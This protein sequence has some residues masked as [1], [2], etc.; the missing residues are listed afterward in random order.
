MA[1]PA[2]APLF[3]IVQ[4]EVS[5]ELDLLHGRWT[6]RGHANRPLAVVVV[7]TTERPRRR[8]RRGR[9][10]DAAGTPI[11]AAR[12]T[13]VD[14]DPLEVPDPER[15]LADVD[16]PAALAAA[17]EILDQL[18]HLHA[19]ASEEPTPR[20]L[21]ARDLTR[22]TV[23]YGTGPEGADGRWTSERRLAVLADKPARIRRTGHGIGAEERLAELLSGRDAPL[24]AETLGLRAHHDLAAGRT[25]EAALQLRIA[26]E[27]AIVELEPWRDAPRLDEALVEL[28]DARGAVAEVAAAAVRGGLDDD[29]VETVRSVLDLLARALA[30]RAG[31]RRVGEQPPR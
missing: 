22:A 3:R 13:V 11:P 14:A 30:R 8:F 6:I 24:A 20:P 23:A 10:A 31:G 7:A 12:L 1:S 28:R 19:I 4:V 25:R 27:A 17:L 9:A 2:P 29:Q 15:W 18:L 21:R 16:G 5:G 26:L